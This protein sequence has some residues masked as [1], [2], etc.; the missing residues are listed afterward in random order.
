MCADDTRTPEEIEAEFITHLTTFLKDAEDIDDETLDKL[1]Q[2]DNYNELRSIVSAFVSL[3]VLSKGMTL[4]YENDRDNLEKIHADMQ[5]IIDGIA[6][7]LQKQIK[8]IVAEAN[9]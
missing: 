9:K 1:I 5:D 2:S 6:G 8:R 3:P 7:V 4:L